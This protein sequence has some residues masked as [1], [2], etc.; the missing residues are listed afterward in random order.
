[1]KVYNQDKTEILESYDLELGYL[2]Q[3]KIL[4]AEHEATEEVKEVS[5]YDI[6]KTYPN[7]GKDVQRVVEVP[8]QPAKEAWTEYEDIY[9][10]IPYSDEKIK[11][12]KNNKLN[13]KYIPSA[14]ESI[15]VFA[16]AY[17][18]SNP[19]QDVETK[20][21]VSGLYSLWVKGKYA[22]GDIVNY[23]GQTYECTT[24]HDNAEYPDITPD[25]PQTWANFWKPLHGKSIETARPWVKPWAGTTDM[26]KVDEYMIYADN[27]IY[28]CIADTVYSPEEYAQAWEIVM[29]DK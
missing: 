20:L 2:V 5:R 8:Y 29:I 26:Y 4:I 10:Y 25:N 22:V 13:A 11:E 14:S 27:L 23:M 16:N 24:A 28:R 1:M 12:I 19:L 7:G 17:L 15:Q 18:K 6:V 3:D 9:V 21:A